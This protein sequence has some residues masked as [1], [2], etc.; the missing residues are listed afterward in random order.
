ML[1]VRVNAALAADTSYP[2]VLDQPIHAYHEPA[3]DRAEQRPGKPA[4]EKVKEC[5]SKQVAHYERAEVADAASREIVVGAFGAKELLL[6]GRPSAR[7][8]TRE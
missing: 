1:V 4:Q 6:K 3:A 5:A 7:S 8:T 2:W